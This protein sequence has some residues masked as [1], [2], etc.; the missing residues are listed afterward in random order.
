MNQSK[1]ISQAYELARMQ[2]EALGVDTEAALS[3]LRPFEI[4]LHCWQAD[5]VG[6][7]EHPDASL[8]GGGIAVTGNYPGKARTIEE[9]RTDL[10][11]VMSLLPGTQRLN[12]HASYGEFGE[13]FVD[14]DQI[15]P[16]HFQGWIQ[17]ARAQNT[18][19]D[20]NC[21]CFSHP[22]A[23][24]GFTLSSKQEDIRRFWVEHARRCRAIGAEMGQQLGKTCIHNIWI[25]DGS[26]DITVNRAMHRELLVESLD[27]ILEKPFPK[28][29]L[30]DTV[31]GK[32]FGIGSESFTTGSYDFSLGYA[33][34]RNTGLC[35]DIG[36]FHPTE[37]VADKISAVLQ[38]IDEI[39]LHITRGIHWDSDHIV[40]MNDP[41]IE[42]M[43]E[44]VWAGA[45]DRVCF[46]LDYFDA[47][48]NRVG[49]YVIGIRAAQKALLA[50]LLSPLKKLREYERERRYFE[51]L[52]LL[53][54]MKTLPLGD[55][56]NYFCVL[57]NVPPAERYIGE[58]SRY[59]REVL[60]KR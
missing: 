32:L 39:L 9:L 16:A 29:H 1:T 49:A 54:E 28:Q 60:T 13:G 11:K 31:E 42:L 35:L 51:R 45:L 48:V 21:T 33:V 43:Q 38:F 20:F 47:S 5:D 53:E 8:G 4:S 24:S 59:E 52:A 34:K 23:D 50:A 12:L 15:E 10:E 22:K 6:G 2:Y 7:F 56:W 25:P 44:V 3:R 26:K 14:R 37:S 41:V 36:H 30:I 57:N 46:G 27:A 19:L 18:A 58:I 17:W 55:V 40:L